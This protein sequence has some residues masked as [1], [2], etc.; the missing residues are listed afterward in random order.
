MDVN[1]GYS[2]DPDTLP[3]L[4]HFLE[5]MLFLGTEKYPDEGYYQAFLQE[6]GGSSNAY[7]DFEH[8]N[9][10]FDVLHPHLEQV[11]SLPKPLEPHYFMPKLI[12]RA[13]RSDA[14]TMQGI[15]ES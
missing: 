13:A 9:F 10:F 14:L 8:T 12:A 15:R 4:A 5:H 2:S 1:V 7:T 3:G 6:R 11:V